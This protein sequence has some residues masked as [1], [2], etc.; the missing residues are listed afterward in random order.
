MTMAGYSKEWAFIDL[1]VVAQ[2]TTCRV[3]IW[4]QPI[5]VAVY[6]YMCRAND[7]IVFYGDHSCGHIWK[8]PGNYLVIAVVMVIYQ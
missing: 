7:I 6:N 4:S 8:L 2:S 3:S 1:I 5:S